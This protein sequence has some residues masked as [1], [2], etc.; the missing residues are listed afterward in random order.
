M[1]T[2]VLLIAPPRLFHPAF[3]VADDVLGLGFRVTDEKGKDG[4]L[5][6]VS[7]AGR[8]ASGFG[9]RVE[10]GNRTVQFRDV[11]SAIARLDDQW[12]RDDLRPFLSSQSSL[13]GPELYEKMQAT[14]RKHVYFDHP[15]EYVIAACW[16]L[17]TYVYPIFFVSAVP[18]PVG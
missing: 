2:S 4:L 13:T 17:M 8:V 10:V 3:D 11:E 14:W 16:C 9:E 7:V 6:V 18:S 1:N 5:H 12:D 15:G